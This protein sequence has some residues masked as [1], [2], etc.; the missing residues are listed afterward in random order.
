[1]EID[2]LCNFNIDYSVEQLNK[3]FVDGVVMYVNIH[4]HNIGGYC[5]SIE[6]CN[7]LIWDGTY[8]E[9]T[10]IQLKV[11]L[12]LKVK[13]YND[14]GSSKELNDIVELFN[15]L[16]FNTIDSH[17]I[18]HNYCCRRLREEIELLTGIKLVRPAKY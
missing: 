4:E 12:Q 9:N 10:G 16:D 11:S 18:F 8:Y 13:L 17:I 3:R 7:K 15:S 6:Y 14:R 2:S 5:I 1:M